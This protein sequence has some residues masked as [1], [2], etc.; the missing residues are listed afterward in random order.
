MSQWLGPT[1]SKNISQKKK[2]NSKNNLPLYI[3]NQKKKK[4]KKQRITRPITDPL[5]L[6]EQ[7]E[8]PPQNLKTQKKKEKEENRKI[9]TYWQRI[10]LKFSNYLKK[11]SVNVYYETHIK[12]SIFKN[13]LL[14]NK[15]IINI[16]SIFNIFF[17]I[18]NYCLP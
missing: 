16:F 5:T 11:N 2:K 8:D 18:I 9:H 3:S 13:I 7:E 17:K 14:K 12:L 1:N 10:K 4:E 15:K 6:T